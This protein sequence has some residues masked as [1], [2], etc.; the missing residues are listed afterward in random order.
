MKTIGR[1]FIILVAFVIVMGVTYGIVNASGTST[2]MPQLENRERP[3]FENGEMPQFEAGERPELPGGQFEGRPEGGRERGGGGWMVGLIKN[4][5]I[6]TIVV[7]LIAVP[8]SIMRNKK[9][10]EPVLVE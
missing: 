2:G 5:G 10:S 9:R 1:I 3:Q 6:L 8:R 7:A 4:V